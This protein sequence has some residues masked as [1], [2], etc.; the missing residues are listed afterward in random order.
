MKVSAELFALIDRSIGFSELTQGAFDITFASVGFLYD[1]RRGK[2]P[3]QAQLQAAA[4]LVN[5][6]NLVM[7]AVAH[8]IGFTR[9][10]VRVDLGGIAKGYAVDR[11]VAVLR[12]YDI[13]EGLVNAGGEVRTTGGTWSIGI[14]H[15][16]SPSELA[17]V[18]DVHG[19]AIATS[20][21]Y[22]Q[23]FEADGV[24]YHHIFDPA[25]GLP[26]RECQSVS[27]IA[28]DDMTADALA[29]AV[30]VMGPA[31]GMEFLKQYPDIE[32]LII[33][34]QGAEHV[35]PGFANYRTR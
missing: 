4:G 6:Q 19:R 23:Y 17:A 34:E 24:R 22:E 31:D 10:G 15:P 5:Y 25:T 28:D 7:D 14:Q 32:A 12:S 9:P 1:Y 26:A 8:T 30:F 13:A 29:T 20:G 11:A 3:D 33:D 21:D 2:R 35:T 27:V 16:R 18:V